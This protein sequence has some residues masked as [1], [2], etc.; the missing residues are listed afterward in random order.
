MGGDRA[1]PAIEGIC[2][3]E[4]LPCNAGAVGS[5]SGTVSNLRIER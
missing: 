1:N 3:L 2:F 4:I 5:K